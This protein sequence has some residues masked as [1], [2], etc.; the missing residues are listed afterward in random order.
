MRDPGASGVPRRRQ[1]QHAP[2][3][4]IGNRPCDLLVGDRRRPLVA[5]GERDDPRAVVNRPANPER[6]RVW[7]EG[8]AVGGDADR[9]HP[10]QPAVPGNSLSIVPAARDDRRAERPVS[11]RVHARRAVGDEVPA[12]HER[13]LQVRR[14][15]IDARVHNCDHDAGIALGDI[16]G[17]RHVDRALAPGS[18][19]GWIVRRDRCS[20]PSAREHGHDDRQKPPP[21]PHGAEFN[22]GSG[23]RRVSRRLQQIPPLLDRS[24][25]NRPFNL[26]NG[27]QTL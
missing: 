18:R 1:H 19:P 15:R 11:T 23:G 25:H 8:I 5:E 16:P 10:A 21:G 24:S 17:S 22:G 20:V 9:H 3:R 26:A 7:I 2:L 27:R 4:R 6:G 14:G 12:V 13:V